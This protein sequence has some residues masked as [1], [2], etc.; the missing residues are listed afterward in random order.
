MRAAY[1]ALS[2]AVKERVDGLRA[3]HSVS[4]S[5]TKLGYVSNSN[6]KFDGFKLGA[7][8][9]NPP[10]RSLVKTHPET[11]RQAL[12]IGRHAHGIPGLSET[13]SEKLLEELESF[14]CRPPRVYFHR[15]TPG[16]VVVWDNRCLMHRA[17][18]WDMREPRVMHQ[19]SIAGDPF[20]EFAAAT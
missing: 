7:E 1:D 16:D 12:M 3:Y 5:Q 2:P 10:L 4:Y 19:T 14:G 9:K 13:E 18:P 15:W 11:G 8:V 17:C 20:T 6:D